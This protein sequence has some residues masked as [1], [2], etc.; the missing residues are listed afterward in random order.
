MDADEQLNIIMR[1]T[2][3]SKETAE[4]KLKEHTGDMISVIREYNGPSRVNKPCATKFSVN[5]QIYKEIR[6]M[7]DD[8]AKT[9]QTKKELDELKQSEQAQQSGQQEQKKEQTEQK[10]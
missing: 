1:Q 7:M 8:A 3:Y 9:Y 10:Q 6:G 4:Q 5:Q 2:D